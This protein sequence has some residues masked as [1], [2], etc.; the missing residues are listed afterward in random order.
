VSAGRGEGSNTI[1]EG[2]PANTIAAEPHVRQV[3]LLDGAVIGLRRLNKSDMDTVIALHHHLSD[4]GQYF[5]FFT[6][7]PRYLQEF[8]RKVVQRTSANYAVGAFED[9]ELIGV[10]NFVRCDDPAVAEVA[11]AVAHRDHLRGVATA[12]LRHLG[13]VARRKGI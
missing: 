9:D 1:T 7:H 5:R 10:A 2:A 3:T 12:L 8:A 11:I 6:V 13:H 4:W